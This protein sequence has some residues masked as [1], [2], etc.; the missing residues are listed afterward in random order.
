M[1]ITPGNSHAPCMWLLHV[2][3]PRDPCTWPLCSS[4]EFVE[5]SWLN[6][7]SWF[8]QKYNFFG[9]PKIRSVSTWRI[10]WILPFTLSISLNQPSIFVLRLTVLHFKY[11]VG[12]VQDGVGYLFYQ[13][14]KATLSAKPPSHSDPV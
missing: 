4:I 9:A 1:Q 2:T 10:T 5:L 14:N 12:V 6:T 8:R 3:S 13:K 11:Q 7:S